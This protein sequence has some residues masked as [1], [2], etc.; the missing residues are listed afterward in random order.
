VYPTFT[1]LLTPFISVGALRCP[2]FAD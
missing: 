2:I 1:P